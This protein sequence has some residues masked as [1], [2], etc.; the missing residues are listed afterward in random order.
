MARRGMARHGMARPGLAPQACKAIGHHILL[1]RII[2]E[3]Q[4]RQ[5]MTVQ[6]EFDT[7]IICPNDPTA[8]PERIEGYKSH[9]TT[10]Y[11]ICKLLNPKTIVEI[12]VRAGYSSWAFF[13]ACP[14]ATIY[15]FDNNCGK[16]GGQGGEK[17]EYKRW[18][19]KILA[20]YHFKSFNLDTQI[21]NKLP[22]VDEIDFM[23][24]DGDHTRQGVYNDLVLAL[25]HVKA[26]GYI[27]IDDIDYIPEV[28]EGVSDFIRLYKREIE[29]IYLPSFRGEMLIRK[30]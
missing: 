11:L 1:K 8:T 14:D 18:A 9:Y 7:S 5:I 4:K 29:H 12:G 19:K 27:L 24:I 17:G 6:F 22:L 15:G 23:H 13:Q 10:K 20:P 30:K 16:H 28:L 3:S 26:G 25:K 2:K 21:V